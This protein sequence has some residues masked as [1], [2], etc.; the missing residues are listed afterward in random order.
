[1]SVF[2]QQGSMAGEGGGVGRPGG[3]KWDDRRKGKVGEE[4]AMMEKVHLTWLIWGTSEL[5]VTEAATARWGTMI[6]PKYTQNKVPLPHPEEKL[7]V[8]HPHL[9]PPS[10]EAHCA[11]EFF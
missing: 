10:T 7:S 2:R 3:L 5:A 8:P 11:K 1:M 9:L 6:P 4:R